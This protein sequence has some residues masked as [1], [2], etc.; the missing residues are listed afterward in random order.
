MLTSDL[1]HSPEPEDPLAPAPEGKAFFVSVINPDNR[2]GILAGPY[3][4]HQEAKDA[5]P[6]AIRRADEVDRF[7]HFYVFGTCQGPEDLKT[8]FGKLE[9]TP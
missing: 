2:V 9:V 8:V 4:T 5:T 7:S 1:T 6:E 3:S